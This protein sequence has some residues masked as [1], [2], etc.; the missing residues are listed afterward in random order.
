[1]PIRFYIF[2]ALLCAPF[3]GFTADTRNPASSGNATLDN[4]VVTATRTPQALSNTLA[5]TTVIERADI[6]RLQVRSV[7]ELLRR[8]PGVDIANSGGPGKLTSVFLRGTESDHVL[9]LIDGVEYRSATAGQAAFQDIPVAQIERIEVVRGPRSSLYGSEAIGGVIQIFTR[10]G[11]GATKP[12][13]SLGAG[14]YDTYE[15]QVGLSGGSERSSYHIGLSGTQSNGF[16]ACTGRAPDPVT[17]AGGAGCFT[18]EPDDDGYDRVSGS[19]R[20]SYRFDNDVDLGI[21]LLRAE[22]D[23]EFDGSFTNQ[24]DTLQQVYGATLDFAP[25]KLWSARL[26]VGRSVDESTDFLNDTFASRFRTERDTASLQNDVR[27]GSA[28]LATLGLDYRREHVES[29]TDFAQTRRDNAGLFLQYQGDFGAQQ[30]QLAARGDDNEQFGQQA[31]GSAAWGWNFISGYSLTL[32]YGTAFKAPSFNDLYFPGFSNP[33]LEP[34]ESRSFDAGLVARPDWGRWSLH[35]F[36]TRIDELI[37][38]D[39]AFIPQNISQTRLQ[40]LEADVQ[41]NY[42]AWFFNANAN[43]LDAENRQFGPNRGNELPRR[44]E[45]NAQFD[46]DRRLG[47]Y[48]LGGG[49]Y[50]SGPRFDDLANTRRLA[51]YEL[52]E[53]RGDMR[54]NKDWQLQARIANLLDEDYETVAFFNQPGR[55]L[56]VTLR[57]Q[58][59]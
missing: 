22:G 48:S 7:S 13:F 28:H 42:G 36:N 53:L 17:F 11:G 26:A 15:G 57:Y 35:A 39:A 51:S 55:S 3:S 34:E 40:G 27:L 54:I 44:A 33:D 47:R 37:A 9:V 29:S 46:V 19:L 5:P 49:V 18:D 10:D 2:A 25:A 38:L 32:S 14:R 31:T 20:A 4:I 8:T 52:L 30:I 21:N 56:F 50:F 1:M 43:L 45:Y 24:S 58:P 41:V 59:E 16:N 6:E 12:Y 23:N